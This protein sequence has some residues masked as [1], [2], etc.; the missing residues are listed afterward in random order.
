MNSIK[1]LKSLLVVVK[2][3]GKIPATLNVLYGGS[4]IRHKLWTAHNSEGELYHGYGI[5]TLLPVV[6]EQ[7]I[8]FD[9]IRFNGVNRAQYENMVFSV[10]MGSE[11][12]MITISTKLNTPQV[13]NRQVCGED[14]DKHDH[15]QLEIKNEDN[16]DEGND[17]RKSG[18]ITGT[19]TEKT[20]DL[21]TPSETNESVV[22][23]G[24]D[25][26]LIEGEGESNPEGEIENPEGTE[27]TE[28]TPESDTLDSDT[29]PDFEHAQSLY[30]ESDK[31]GSKVKLEEYAREFGAELQ[32]NKTFDNMM[33]DFK[34]TFE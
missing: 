22:T 32:R 2:E 29:L 34:A 31:S 21:G 33:L 17:S 18:D 30:D 24:S 11:E 6:V 13:G 26:T 1:S 8:D 27:P 5:N 3:A 10:D 16:V 9:T 7:D 20:E 25:E 14:C 28:P 23:E 12:D 15:N 19:P 4:R